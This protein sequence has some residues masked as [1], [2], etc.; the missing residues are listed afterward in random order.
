MSQLAVLIGLISFPGLIA[1]IVCDKLLVHAERWNTFKYTVYTFVFGVSSYVLLQGIVWIVSAFDRH[2]PFL[3]PRVS[4]QLWG[5][6]ISG[7]DLSFTE[8]AWATGLSPAVALFATTCVNKKVLHRLAQSVGISSKYGDENLFSYFLNSPDVYWVYVRDKTTGQTYRGLV[9]SFSETKELQEVVLTNVTVY[10][11]ED[12]SVLYELDAIYL[13][14]PLGTFVI[15]APSS[16]HQG[17]PDDRQAIAAQRRHGTPSGEG[18]PDQGD[19]QASAAATSA[20]APATQ[21]EVR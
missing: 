9:R 15:E 4:L 16:L 14:K 6:L 8:V 17:N 5:T 20:P 2:M 7:R 12:S 21:E 18:R 3:Q 11:Y 10:N 19:K 1:T 13:S